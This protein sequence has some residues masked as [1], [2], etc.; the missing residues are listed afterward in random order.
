MVTPEGE[1]LPVFDA[2][3]F[4]MTGEVSER[5]ESAADTSYSD[6]ETADGAEVETARASESFVADATPALPEPDE[7]GRRWGLE[8]EVEAVIESITWGEVPAG[9]PSQEAGPRHRSEGDGRRGRDR[10]GRDRGGRDR[11]GRD[12]GRERS[13]QD[14]RSGG[15][16][17]HS[18]HADRRPSERSEVQS[19]GRSEGREEVAREEGRGGSRNDR[20]D[21]RR[22]GGQNAAGTESRAESRSD[23]GQS[24]RGDRRHGG[25][26]RNGDQRRSDHRDRRD[27]RSEPK[28]EAAPSSQGPAPIDLLDPLAAFAAANDIDLSAL[29]DSDELE[30]TG[31]ASSQ[32]ARG[33][34]SSGSREQ[35]DASQRRGRRRRRGG[36]RRGGRGNGGQAAGAEG[37]A[38]AGESSGDADFDDGG[39]EE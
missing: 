2:S 13:G 38:G 22:S 19:D 23:R 37:S 3:G 35:G 20:R 12:R 36:R 30:D 28:A 14:E 27:Q 6:S 24:P 5:F 9:E 8:P 26:E 1:A 33:A 7:N 18:Q 10:G 4:R 29:I 25:G 32:A 15:D 34:H 21:N 17:R 39:D 31:T 16:A 11:G